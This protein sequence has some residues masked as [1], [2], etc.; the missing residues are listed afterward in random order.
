MYNLL[1]IL[2]YFSIGAL[3]GLSMGIIGIGAGIITLPLLIYS[4]MHIEG[5]VACILFM[6]LLPQSLPA[7]L[8]YSKSEHIDYNISM[9]VILGSVIGTLLGSLI[10]YYDLISE[11]TT[12]KLLTIVIIITAIIFT[13]RYLL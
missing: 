7:V 4:G 6:Q 9:L 5:A 1:Y 12:Y 3:A 13:K 2:Q 11:K 10:I 8:V